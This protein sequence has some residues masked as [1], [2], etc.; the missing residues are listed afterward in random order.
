MNWG[1]SVSQRD[2]CCCVLHNCRDFSGTVSSRLA[3]DQQAGWRSGH[4]GDA[5]SFSLVSQDSLP[6]QAS[7]PLKPKQTT[8]LQEEDLRTATQTLP[9]F[10]T[11]D[12]DIQP[13]VILHSPGASPKRARDHFLRYTQQGPQAR[14]RNR[15]GVQP[16][17]SHALGS[18]FCTDAS[19]CLP[20][21]D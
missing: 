14:G 16:G 6:Y 15:P 19:W 17:D 7:L 11:S 20:G 8:A 9:G 10:P 1:I 5:A 4:P 18:C 12:L 2:G 13:P 21:S 3:S